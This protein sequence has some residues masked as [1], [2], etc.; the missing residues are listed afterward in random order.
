M[1]R[2]KLSVKFYANSQ[3]REPVRE[4]LLELNAADRKTIGDEIRTVQFG[5]PIGMPLVRKL[6][7]DLW[8]IRIDLMDRIVRVVFTIEKGHAILLHGFIK[9]TQKIPAPDLATA[10][11]RLSDLRATG[12]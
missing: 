12:E 11:R 10:K 7:K 1:N 3:G 6:D 8:E 4:W 9:K 2:P 5:W